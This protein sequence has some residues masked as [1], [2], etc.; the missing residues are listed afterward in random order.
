MAKGD[1]GA[2]VIF[3]LNLVFGIYIIASA[4]ELAALPES[5]V[6]LDKWIF[7]IGGILIIIG[8]INYLRARKRNKYNL[9]PLQQFR[10]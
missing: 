10:R 3:L 4:L 6:K 7:V 9:P 8:G 2:A 1:G 5:L